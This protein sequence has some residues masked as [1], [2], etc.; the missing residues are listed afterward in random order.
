MLTPS[1]GNI[2]KR[3]PILRVRTGCLTCR[4]RKKK[5]DESKPICAGCRRNKLTC[6]WPTPQDN[7][8]PSDMSNV[9]PHHDGND[10]H[11]SSMVADTEATA[12][13]S[14]DFEAVIRTT[15]PAEGSSSSS[16]SA[17]Q[18]S[19]PGWEYFPAAPSST[20]GL[21]NAPRKR[22]GSST[23]QDDEHETVEMKR[24]P[25]TSSSTS[26]V[27]Y[28]TQPY[29]PP[30]HSSR[31]E[32]IF[33]SLS[34][35]PDLEDRSFELLNYYLSR[36]A[37]SMFNGST[38]S[39]PFIDQLVP[40]SFANNFILRLLLSQSASHRAITESDSK[41][42]AQKDYIM[43]LRLFQ[44]AIDDYVSGRE[45]SPL[46]VAMGALIMCFTEVCGNF[47]LLSLGGH[48]WT[49]IS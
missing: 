23:S 48:R 41:G 43:S 12:S 7:V 20:A 34:M 47:L 40:L 13:K 33:K 2:R 3:G 32:A 26:D 18:S 6:Q 38:E 15:P 37:M 4:A 1:R 45:S 44:N 29:F 30:Q 25:G 46:W 8:R 27:L 39:N 11:P 16:S 35:V 49:D 28:R 19:T 42:L 10:Q 31:T 17:S 14:M 36:T 9:S 24:E 21:G 5:C 22:E